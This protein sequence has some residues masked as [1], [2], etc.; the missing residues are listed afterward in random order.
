MDKILQPTTGQSVTDLWR[1]AREGRLT[2]SSFGPVCKLKDTTNPHSI[3]KSTLGYSDVNTPATRW[4]TSHEPAAQ[5][6][7]RCEADLN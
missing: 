7:Y 4:G 5:R 3:L 2:S 1:K 6:V